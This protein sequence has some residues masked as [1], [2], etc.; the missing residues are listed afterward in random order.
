ML[1]SRIIPCLNFSHL[2]S[3]LIHLVL[4]SHPLLGRFI[5]DQQGSGGGGRAGGAVAGVFLN[6]SPCPLL[7]VFLASWI[8]CKL[9]CTL[10]LKQFRLNHGEGKEE[11][12]WWMRQ[13]EKRSSVRFHRAC[14]AVLG[15]EKGIFVERGS[16][17]PWGKG[18]AVPSHPMCCSCCGT[19]WDELPV[20]GVLGLFPVKSI[21]NR[22]WKPKDKTLHKN[23]HYLGRKKE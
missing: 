6:R 22:S 1:Y 20:T 15:K 4:F 19:P 9:L 3:Y 23:A 18:D 11:S 14:R 8:Y 16:Y 5:P 10:T 21:L 2:W 13:S 7:F 12:S 17:L